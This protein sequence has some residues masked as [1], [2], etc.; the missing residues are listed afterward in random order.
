M[1]NN[2]NVSWINILS[3]DIISIK[4]L[5]MTYEGRG[6][7]EILK[8]LAV[9]PQ[10]DETVYIPSLRDGEYTIVASTKVVKGYDYSPEKDDL[11]EVEEKVVLRKKFTVSNERLYRD[12]KLGVIISPHYGSGWY[13]WLLEP[14]LL[15]H[16]LLVRRVEQNAPLTLEWLEETLQIDLGGLLNDEDLIYKKLKVVWVPKGCSFTINSYDGLESIKYFNPAEYILA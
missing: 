13:T 4:G 14:K 6:L 3:A 7:K 11:E 8:H 10:E 16:P 12:N 15:T 1:N 9:P 2:N 5:F